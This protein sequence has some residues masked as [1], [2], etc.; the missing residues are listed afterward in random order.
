MSRRPSKMDYEVGY[1]KPPKEHRF[2][3]GQS[4][5]RRG[6]P[7]RLPEIA[8]LLAKELRRKHTIVEGG[9]RISV[10]MIH[11]LIKRLLEKAAKGHFLA[12][13]RTLELADQLQQLERR[14]AITLITRD[15]TPAQAAEAYAQM[16]RSDP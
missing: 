7:K 9:Q 2:K 16:I 8:D 3:P 13:M 6:R 11:L 4:G 10:A 1:G 12:L 5:N 15:M 14:S